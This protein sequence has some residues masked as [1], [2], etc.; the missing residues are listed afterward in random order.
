MMKSGSSLSV[1]DKKALQLFRA[2]D[3]S[4]KQTAVSFMAFLATQASG[5]KSQ[6]AIKPEP[7]A[8]PKEESVI[9]AIKRLRSSY[10]MLDQNQ[11]FHVTSE[12]MMD[13][14]M[15]G[16]TA[17]DVID[18]LEILFLQKYQVYLKAFSD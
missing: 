9:K 8:K 14:L 10:P 6:E 3:A 13:H 15:H 5:Q 1:E 11:L 16:K 4:Q 12:K 18:E 2:L 7:I 17:P